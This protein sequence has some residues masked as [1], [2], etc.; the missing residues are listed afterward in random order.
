MLELS[1]GSE[2]KLR[3][4]QYGIYKHAAVQI[5]SWTKKAILKRG[6]CYKKKFYGA[7]THSCMEFTPLSMWCSQN[8]VFCWRPVEYMK[9]VDF[10]NC[11]LAGPKEIIENLIEER[12][13]LLSGFGGNENA[14]KELLEDSIIPTH[15][16]ISLSGEPTLYPMLGELVKY[17]K[18]LPKTRTIF[19]V[20]NGL[21]TSFFESCLEN[22]DYLPTQLYFSL[23]APTKEIQRR[24]NLPKYDDAWDRLIRSLELY[25]K[26]DTRKVLRITLIKGIND[27]GDYIDKFAELIE[28][29][30][31]DFIE[32][33]AYMH[34]GM[35]QKRLHK[36]NMPD[37][38]YVKKWTMKLIERIPYVYEDEQY[39]SRIVLL[40]RKDTKYSTKIEVFENEKS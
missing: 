32:V 30:K 10:K 29:G 5:C 9:L 26:L 8:C 21:E 1:K 28:I 40:K 25:S 4:K 19:I 7:D 6:V 20:T 27:A 11:E 16:A 15:Y 24:I 31:P 18:S 36:E 2:E 33:K 12:K 13:K 35:S 39:E 34:L 22:P 17:L 37:H 14:D 3:K 38:D 23:E